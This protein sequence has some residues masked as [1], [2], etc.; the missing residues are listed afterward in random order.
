MSHLG[1][2]SERSRE[3][4]RKAAGKP[5]ARSDQHLGRQPHSLTMVY[6]NMPGPPSSP[7]FAYCGR[8]CLIRFVVGRSLFTS[9]RQHP[10]YYCYSSMKVRYN[11]VLVPYNC[12]ASMHPCQEA[13]ASWFYLSIGHYWIHESGCKGCGSEF[14]WP[15]A[16]TTGCNRA[17]GSSGIELCLT[18]STDGSLPR[19]PFAVPSRIGRE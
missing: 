18:R 5:P 6:S 2:I 7:Q 13:R 17:H 12:R 4:S 19:S 10:L 8:C 16:T 9:R 14:G 1:A 11:I 3:P 15:L